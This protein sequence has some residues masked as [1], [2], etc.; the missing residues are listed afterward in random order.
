MTRFNL[1]QDK[2]DRTA[3]ATVFNLKLLKDKN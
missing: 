1:I 2:G 3:P